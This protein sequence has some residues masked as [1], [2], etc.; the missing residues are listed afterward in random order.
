MRILQENFESFD[1]STD[2]SDKLAAR[3]AEATSLRAS[4]IED[5]DSR[6]RARRTRGMDDV[7]DGR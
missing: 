4:P 7:E 3:V 2:T 1:W 6:G 5:R